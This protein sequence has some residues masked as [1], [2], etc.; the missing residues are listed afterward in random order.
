MLGKSCNSMCI[1]EHIALCALGNKHIHM[2]LGLLRDGH[3]YT[4]Q[5]QLLYVPKTHSRLSHVTLCQ[6]K[7][8]TC[9]QKGTLA[10]RRPGPPS[11]P[12]RY[13]LAGRPA[14]SCASKQDL[15]RRVTNTEKPLRPLRWLQVRHTRRSEQGA[16]KSTPGLG[17]PTAEEVVLAAQ[18]LALPRAALRRCLL[19]ALL[20]RCR[21]LRR[22]RSQLSAATQTKS[23]ASQEA[24]RT[25]GALTLSGF[26]ANSSSISCLALTAPR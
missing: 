17:S 26:A 15:Q 2:H 14:A 8:S 7:S 21:R 5:K 10:C 13:T 11:A 19:R 16:C 24:R 3:G 22:Q 20:R 25:A 4:M 12:P 18:G 23:L 9:S 6:L 1:S